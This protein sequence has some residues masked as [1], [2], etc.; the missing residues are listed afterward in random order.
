MKSILVASMAIL[1][2][3]GIAIADSGARLS[4][5]PAALLAGAAAEGTEHVLPSAPVSAV[6]AGSMPIVLGSTKLAD[7]AGSFGGDIQSAADGAASA[8]WLCYARESDGRVVE[9]WFVSDG[10]SGGADRAV[11]LVV[12]DYAP[13]RKAGCADPSASLTRIDFSVPGLDAT[14][15]DLEARFGVVAARDGLVAYQGPGGS[16]LQTL[17]YHLVDGRVSG[18]AVSE[19]GAQ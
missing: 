6:T 12:N 10:A 4:G 8:S 14:P 2:S 13:S 17:N 15:A 11:T 9:Y 5:A 18:L 1:F 16:G 19:I 3:C 7:V